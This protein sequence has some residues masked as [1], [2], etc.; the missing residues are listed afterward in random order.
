MKLYFKFRVLIDTVEYHD[1]LL[2]KGMCLESHDLF[3]FLAMSDNISEAVQDR[4]M[5]AIEV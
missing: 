5:V 3:K 4:D 1:I 2:Q